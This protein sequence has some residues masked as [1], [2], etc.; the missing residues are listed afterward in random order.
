[1]LKIVEFKA[2]KFTRAPTLRTF[3]ARKLKKN[4]K[5]LTKSKALNLV[6]Q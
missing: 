4:N 3:R 6:E 1:M 5:K 2:L